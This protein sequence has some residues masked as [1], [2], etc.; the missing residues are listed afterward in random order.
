MTGCLLHKRHAHH[1]RGGRQL[2]ADYCQKLLRVQRG[3][4]IEGIF[5]AE[6]PWT[7]LMIELRSRFGGRSHPQGVQ[8]VARGAQ[9][10]PL[11]LQDLRIHSRLQTR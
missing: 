5:V 11:A 3:M 1:R 10:W 6:R 8:T 9:F 7:S 2:R 4:S